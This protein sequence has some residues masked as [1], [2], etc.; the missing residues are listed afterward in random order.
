L[1]DLRM[2]RITNGRQSLHRLLLRQFVSGVG[3]EG[4]YRGVPS[5]PDIQNL[6]SRHPSEV[7]SLQRAEGSLHDGQ[8]RR[9][10]EALGAS[11][12]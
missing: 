11:N 9:L 8:E 4:R 5:S 1:S 12:G 2:F 6:R 10:P 3:W 7:E